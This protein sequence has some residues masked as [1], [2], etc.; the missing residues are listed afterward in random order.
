MRAGL[1]LRLEKLFLMRLERASYTQS[2]SSFV[3]GES[4]L[5]RLNIEI[6]TGMRRMFWC[7]WQI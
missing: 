6:G 2:I 7:N 4:E 1:G 3:I 5:V